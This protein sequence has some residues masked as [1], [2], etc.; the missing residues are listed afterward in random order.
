MSLSTDALNFLSRSR[1][2]VSHQYH[3]GERNKPMESREAI[4]LPYG[5]FPAN[6]YPAACASAS[7]AKRTW[8][9]GEPFTTI[10]G[11]AELLPLAG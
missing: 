4:G 11:Q 5:P 8:F 2:N 6:R 3:S 1:E 9:C 7:V 10:R